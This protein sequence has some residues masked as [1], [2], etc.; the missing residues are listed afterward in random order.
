MP[1][2]KTDQAMHYNNG[3]WGEL[4]Y[5]VPNFGNDTGT[6]NTT[7][8]H[9]TQVIGR[10]LSA[11]MHHIDADLRVPPSINTV[12]RI[13]RLIVRARSI[14]GARSVPSG[15][16]NFEATHSTPARTEFLVY[17]VPYFRVRNPYMKEYSG[18]I[19]NALS[20]AFQHTE[21]RKSYEIS[22]DFGG[23]IG[24]YLQRVYRLMCVELFQIPPDA[25]T[26]TFML[27]DQQLSL[28]NPG[29]FSS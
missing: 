21:N 23:L 24:Q 11:V 1:D 25:V 17:P 19:L 27:S 3:V 22:E 29:A 7:I 8:A 14:I 20:E 28:Y 18:L 12:T 26:P 4:G 10:N 13:H 9:L 5:A 6:H 2:F 16:L 15:V